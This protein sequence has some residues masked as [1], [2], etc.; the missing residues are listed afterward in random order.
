MALKTDLKNSFCMFSF[1]FETLLLVI[2][3]CFPPLA[4]KWFAITSNCKMEFDKSN[5]RAE[6]LNMYIINYS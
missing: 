3:R 4:R 1:T 5:H 2:Q 6:C